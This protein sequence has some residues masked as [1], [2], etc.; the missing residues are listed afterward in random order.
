MILTQPVPNEASLEDMISKTDAMIVKSGLES[1]TS[2]GIQQTPSLLDALLSIGQQW[3]AGSPER[4]GVLDGIENIVAKSHEPRR[5]AMSERAYKYTPLAEGEIRV[6]DLLPGEGKDPIRCHLHPVLIDHYTEYTA[7]SYTWGNETPN[8]VIEVDGFFLYITPNLE[9]A[10]LELRLSAALT[11]SQAEVF[12]S[13]IENVAG[14]EELIKCLSQG[15]MRL[16]VDAICIEQQNHGERATQLKLMHKIYH[17]ANRLLV[18][19][20]EEADD[21]NTA[22]DLISTLSTSYTSVEDDTMPTVAPPNG[23]H[24]WEDF[25]ASPDYIQVIRALNK[26]LSRPWFYRSWILQE[27][28]LGSGSQDSIFQCGKQRVSCSKMEKVLYLAYHLLV[29]SSDVITLVGLVSRISEF[30]FTKLGQVCS[31]MEYEDLKYLLTFSH[32]D[33]RRTNHRLFIQLL[34]LNRKAQ[35]TDPRDKVYSILGI[36]ES[37][38]ADSRNI[39]SYQRYPKYFDL[40]TIRRS[41]SK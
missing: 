26:L 10:L 17:N 39:V 21:S 4:A 24:S 32:R 9:A 11:R 2:E 19:L 1:W 31:S 12:Q 40:F 41:R 8:R 38:K 23:Y 15:V 16:W 14:R 27:Y 18:W 13:Q 5:T 7:L 6:L 33:F 20:G 36:I 34:R 29:F 35:A 3:A 22:M 28:L 25:N 30:A 37:A